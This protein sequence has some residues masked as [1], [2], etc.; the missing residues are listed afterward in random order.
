[1][2]TKVAN[3]VT[4]DPSEFYREIGIR[5]HGKG[6]FH[7]DPVKGRTL[8][9]KRVYEVVPGCLTLNIVFAWERALAVTT[10]DEAGMIASHRFP[11]FQP[12]PER[13]AIEFVLHYM[14]SD[15]GHNVLKLAS[16]GGA[17]RNR[18]ISQEQFLKTS[19][20]LPSVGE[21]HKIITFI[22]A[23]DSE[24]RSLRI[25]LEALKKQKRGLMQQLLT[26]KIRVPKSLLKQGAKP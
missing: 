13:I 12:D 25:Y 8:G 18:T 17:G 6:I 19:I 1:V 9:N 10:N 2:L 7:K 22:N 15:V 5:S 20:P 23:A 11:M 24:L 16:P 14:L 4:V 21:Q 3:A 26:G